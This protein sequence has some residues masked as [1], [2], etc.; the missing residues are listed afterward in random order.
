MTVP[1]AVPAVPALPAAWGR[2]DADPYASAL[3]ASRGPLFLHRADGW[4]LPLEVERWCA[5]P[6]DADDIVLAACR[7][8][9]LDIGCG[10]GRLAA[11]L[12][13]RGVP[14]LGIDVSAEAV[15]RARAAGA[16]ALLRSV[17]DPLPGEGRWSTALLI[18]GNIGI[19]GDPAALLARIRRIVHPTGTLLVE[20]APDGLPD[21]LDEH[22]EVRLTDGDGLRG[23]DFPWSRV[24]PA[25]LLRHATAA[26]WTAGS[27]WTSRGRRFVTLRRESAKGERPD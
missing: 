23:P 16:A 11:A 22:T 5:L 1:L 10:P 15:R 4:L 3:R 6:D 13:A 12:A 25:A 19:G 18:D 17:F 27:F 20:A 24:G 9:V 8:P 21:D 14:A 26:G 2:S 7:G